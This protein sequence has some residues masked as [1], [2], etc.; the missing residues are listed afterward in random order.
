MYGSRAGSGTILPINPEPAVDVLAHVLA[1]G[2]IVRS[3]DK[4]LALDLEKEG[5]A[6]L[7]T[8]AA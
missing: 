8:E 5:Y 4:S 1:G 6:V 2:K 7:G 3:G